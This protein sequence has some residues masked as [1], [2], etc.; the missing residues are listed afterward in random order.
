MLTNSRTQRDY[1]AVQNLMKERFILPEK[2]SQVTLE[3]L[4]R[5]VEKAEA[6]LPSSY[7]CFDTQS[8]R[9]FL[10]QHNLTNQEFEE[11][12]RA[13]QMVT[14]QETDDKRET[15]AQKASPSKQKS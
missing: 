4:S 8:Y 6:K 10:S 3:I 14:G 13:D 9:D 11:M 7:W 12:A 2:V 1:K 5:A 15:N